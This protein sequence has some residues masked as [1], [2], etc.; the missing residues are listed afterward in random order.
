MN[1]VDALF[2]SIIFDVDGGYFQ[3]IQ[4]QIDG[5]NFSGG[6]VVCHLNGEAAAAGTQVQ[7]AVNQFGVFYPWGEVVAEQLV[8]KRARYDDAFVNIKSKSPCHA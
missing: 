6:I 5:V 4:A 1:Q 7:C 2:Q 8:N 3:C